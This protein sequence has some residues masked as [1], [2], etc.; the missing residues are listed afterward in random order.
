VILKSLRSREHRRLR[1]ILI[2]ARKNAGL[3]QRDLGA[4]LK[5]THTILAKVESGERR[6]DVVEFI[7]LARALGVD[8]KGLFAKLLE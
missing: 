2:E 6:L 1:T 5:Q 4:R 7:Y 3:T 8:P